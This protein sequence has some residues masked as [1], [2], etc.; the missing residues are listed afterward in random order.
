M[1]AGLDGRR[2]LGRVGETAKADAQLHP[3]LCAYVRACYTSALGG[4]ADELAGIIGVDSCDAMRGLFN[5]WRLNLSPG[6]SHMLTLP[7]QNTPEAAAFFAGEL[8]GL[9]DSLGGHFG[10]RITD[11]NL[12]AGIKTMNETRSLLQQLNGRRMTSSS[13]SGERF[14]EIITDAMIQPKREFNA[15]LR[16][17]PPEAEESRSGDGVNIVLSGGV[18][19][20]PWIVTAVEK[21]G[22][23]VVADD[24]C[25]GSRYF[26]GLVSEEGDPLLAIARRYLVRV[27]CARMSDTQI[28][29]DRLLKTIEKSRARGLIYYCVKFCDPHTIDWAAVHTELQ[30]RG[31]PSL[32]CETDFSVG[33]RERMRTRIEAFLEMLS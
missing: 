26:E 32:R 3:N 10:V 23:C 31:I 22:G 4:E 29:I 14:Y 17:L 21:A 30:K 24:L 2:I 20:D 18:L 11:E 28:R 1:A 7:R 12:S 27:P 25:C 19:D 9:V 6:F 8:R 13:V 33:A 16:D 5:V 15:G